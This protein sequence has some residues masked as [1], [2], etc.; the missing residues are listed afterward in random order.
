MKDMQECLHLNQ[1][2]VL[3]KSPFNIFCPG[4]LMFCH[5]LLMFN[6]LL[7]ILILPLASR[8]DTSTYESP[9]TKHNGVI[10][11]DVQEPKLTTFGYVYR[12]GASL[13]VRSSQQVLP[14]W[15]ADINA[16]LLQL[17]IGALTK[18]CRN[19]LP[20]LDHDYCI[21]CCICRP[22]SKNASY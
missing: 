2:M 18:S 13:G 15:S 6:K 1:V 10:S 16:V 5:L 8:P 17:L 21:H 22:R 7:C 4:R 19:C 12:Q 3:Q 14:I 11:Q 9:S 20:N